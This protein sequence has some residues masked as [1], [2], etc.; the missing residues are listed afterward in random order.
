MSKS[1]FRQIEKVRKLRKEQTREN[2]EMYYV[3]VHDSRR[4]HWYAF[5]GFPAH[6]R[7]YVIDSLREEG[8]YYFSDIEVFGKIL[9]SIHDVKEWE[10][11]V[12]TTNP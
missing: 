10:Y 5:V 2:I 9:G 8:P 7:I 1:L 4:K 6:S 11:K 3:S 12:C